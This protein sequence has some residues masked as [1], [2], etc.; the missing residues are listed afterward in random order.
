VLL[1]RPQEQFP[2]RIAFSRQTLNIYLPLGVFVPLNLHGMQ[3][4]VTI[5]LCK[6]H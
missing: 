2:H 1:K 3:A 4:N 6:K 5:L